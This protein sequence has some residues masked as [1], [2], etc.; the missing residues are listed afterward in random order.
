MNRRGFFGRLFA[1]ALTPVV[2]TAT[3]RPEESE[4]NM[5]KLLGYV[6]E[7]GFDIR[8]ADEFEE[9]RMFS[10][11]VGTGNREDLLD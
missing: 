9:R 3:P 4:V 11:G 8:D 1:G 6:L 7:E 5:P 2:V 10:G